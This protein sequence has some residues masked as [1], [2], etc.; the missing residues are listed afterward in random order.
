MAFAY[1]D[2]AISQA[3]P[4]VTF[5][6]LR[7]AWQ[8]RKAMSSAAFCDGELRRDPQIMY[9]DVTRIYGVVA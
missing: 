6:L 7:P 3:P 5:H 1:L 4:V 2:A 8:D 9:S